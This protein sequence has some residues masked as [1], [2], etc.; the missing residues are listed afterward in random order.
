MA[1]DPER[2]PIAV[3]VR[4]LEAAGATVTLEELEEELGAAGIVAA[5]ISIWDLAALWTAK[6]LA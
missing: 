3:M 5:E 1:F 2:I 6:V 4:I